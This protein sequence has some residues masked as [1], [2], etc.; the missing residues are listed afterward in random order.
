[1]I[2]HR[3]GGDAELL[4]HIR[5]L[6][7]EL[8]AT[9]DV[10]VDDGSQNAE[11]ANEQESCLKRQLRLQSNEIKTAESETNEPRLAGCLHE[12]RN[13]ERAETHRERHREP[14]NAIGRK[15]KQL[16]RARTVKRPTPGD[17]LAIGVHEENE[18]D[19]RREHDRH[20]V[21][22]H[23]ARHLAPH[24]QRGRQEPNDHPHLLC[25]E[26]HGEADSRRT[27]HAIFSDDVNRGMATK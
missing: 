11:E 24:P 1:M 5:E 16:G 19:R 17:K 22:R 15:R 23:A 8:L 7:N 12:H 9:R 4:R 6:I 3:H 13:R 2:G 18:R 26:L 20:D 27:T 25:V 21:T 14:Q 10:V